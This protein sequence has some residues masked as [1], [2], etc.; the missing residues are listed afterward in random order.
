MLSREEQLN[1]HNTRS[2]AMSSQPPRTVSQDRRAL[3]LFLSFP[4]CKQAE[5]LQ[6]SMITYDDEADKLEDAGFD[7]T[8]MHALANLTAIIRKQERHRNDLSI[9]WALIPRSADHD[10][11]LMKR[12]EA[13]EQCIAD[14]PFRMA[15][16]GGTIAM[17]NITRS[18]HR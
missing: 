5:Q 12:R 9:A 15:G 1:W 18:A 14:Y 2:G 4:P 10:F 16:D 7:L 17:I 11:T 3:E 8:N 6:G 13:I